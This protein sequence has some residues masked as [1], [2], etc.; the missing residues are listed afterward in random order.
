MKKGKCLIC[1]GVI[2]LENENI[3]KCPICN[4]SINY[5]LI[6]KIDKVEQLKHDALMYTIN[7]EYKKLLIFIDNNYNNL[8]LEYYRM[9]SNLKLGNKYD[10]SNFLNSKLVNPELSNLL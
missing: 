1:G 6:A 9:F 10:K 5:S 4:A 2:S 7:K 8:L 3:S